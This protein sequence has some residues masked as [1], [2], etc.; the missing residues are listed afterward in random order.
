MTSIDMA[1]LD[2]F[3]AVARAR[4]FRGAAALRGVS[5]S[6]LSEALRRLE[7]RLGVRLLNRTTHS[8]TP[9][10]AGARLLER[11]APALQEVTA[12]LDAV[13]ALRD[14]SVGTLRLK[15]PS[16]VAQRM[17]PPII[18]GFLA[19][20]PGITMEISADDSFIDVLAAGFDAGIRYDERL[21]RDMIAVPFGKRVQ[22]FVT[23][24]SPAYLAARGSPMHP[25]DLL[26]HACI[27]HR[28][29]SGV[30]SA[31]EFERG[32]EVVKITPAGPLIATTIDL[33]LSAPPKDVDARVKPGHDED[34]AIPRSYRS[35]RADRETGSAVIE[36]SGPFLWSRKRLTVMPFA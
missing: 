21:E 9:T 20:Y 26:S 27:R 8:V 31:W 11:L 34:C 6:S 5:P 2:A 22:R 32:A 1:D 16:V 30:V 33:E 4:S 15:V 18:G 17:L 29:A 14:S 19:A 36:K 13:N 10:D 35:D 23:A 28:F 12:A 7:A 24:G 3:A 25:K